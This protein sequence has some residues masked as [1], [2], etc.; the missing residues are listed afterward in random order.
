MRYV[1]PTDINDITERRIV[2][3]KLTEEEQ[4]TLFSSF[5]FWFLD[6]P[7]ELDFSEDVEE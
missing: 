7:I 5:L 2:K 6:A 1:L 4:K 3:R